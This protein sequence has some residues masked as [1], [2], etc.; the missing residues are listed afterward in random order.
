[1]IGRTLAA[2]Q[3]GQKA[4]GC[5]P[6]PPADVNYV[7]TVHLFFLASTSVLLIIDISK[8]Y[9]KSQQA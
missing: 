5:F 9:A 4:H 6:S 2:K 3:A 8:T 1:M 7:T